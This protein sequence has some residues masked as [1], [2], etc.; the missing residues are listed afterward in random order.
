MFT[1]ILG[2][3]MVFAFAAFTA[4]KPI[5]LSG[6]DPV[7]LVEKKE[8][9]GLPTIFSEVGKYRYL[10]SSSE[11]Q[12]KFDAEPA[13]FAVQ[14]NGH[15][16][17]MPDMEGDPAMWIV[18]E[19]KIYLAGSRDCLAGV[20]AGDD[21]AANVRAE[22]TV[23]ILLFPG[24]EII[25][26]AGP[27]EVFGA[28]GFQVFTVAAKSGPLNANMGQ[29]VVPDYTFENCPPA[30]IFL[31][32]GGAVPRLDKED[33]TLEWIRRKAAESKYTMSVCNG[34]FW[35]ANAGLLEGKSA[36]TIRHRLDQ[37]EKVPG[38][39]VE[40]GKRFVDNGTIITTA[41]L[42]AGIDGAL[43]MVERIIG[44]PT[45]QKIAEVMEYNW[46]RQTPDVEVRKQ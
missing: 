9:K 30:E 10:F 21:L 7:Q 35:L 39:K 3:G 34:A 19:G 5:V 31:L 37:L 8:V 16:R 44:L 27:W 13:R 32:P 28:S 1:P 24:A 12:A 25:D 17:H 14:D 38:V 40:R 4:D 41:G 11:D 22:H 23:A 6:L 43:H 33:P 2:A 46:Q 45:A 42:S 36:T 15:C 26:Y 18:H 20:K 29:V